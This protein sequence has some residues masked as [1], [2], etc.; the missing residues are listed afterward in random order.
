ME[1]YPNKEKTKD[2]KPW[3]INCINV[4]VH[5]KIE[6]KEQWA[7][8]IEWI[9]N[10]LA[11]VWRAGSTL[12]RLQSQMVLTALKEHWE[13]KNTAENPNIFFASVFVVN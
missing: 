11:D 12:E 13:G 4:I 1:L 3:Q 5:V 10:F 7:K 8:R 6:L 2:F 9:L